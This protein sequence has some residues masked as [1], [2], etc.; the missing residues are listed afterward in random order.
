M[1]TKPLPFYTEE[2]VE[3]HNTSDSLWI[4]IDGKVYDVTKF[5]ATVS[6]ASSN[7]DHL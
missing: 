5:Q 2:E 4:I 7:S 1:S 6:K 3:T